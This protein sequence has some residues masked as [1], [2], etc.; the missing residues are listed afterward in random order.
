LSESL[1]APPI[2]VSLPASPNQR[3]GTDATLQ[4]V[5]A[6]VAGQ[7]IVALTADDVL[8]V[9]QRED[10]ART[11]RGDSSPEIDDRNRPV[12]FP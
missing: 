11:T 9:A 5:V 4:N 7:R 8:D 3:V 1:P 12:A 10:A 2:R 6:A